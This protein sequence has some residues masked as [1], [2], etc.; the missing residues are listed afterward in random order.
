MIVRAASSQKFQ[1]LIGL[2]E[3]IALGSYVYIDGG[4]IEAL[5]ENGTYYRIPCKPI[6]PFVSPAALS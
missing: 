4:E 3:A 2:S 1:R 5:Y 6:F